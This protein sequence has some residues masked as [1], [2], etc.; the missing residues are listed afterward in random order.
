MD[1]Q[2]Y[3]AMHKAWMESPWAPDKPRPNHPPVWADG[4]AAA[5][6]LAH[7]PAS[8]DSAQNAARTKEALISQLES[9]SE[10]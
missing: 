2:M 4:F 5:W 6:K 9:L 7:H 10:A 8:T 1:T 3:E